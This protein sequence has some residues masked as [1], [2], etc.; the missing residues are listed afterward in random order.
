[1]IPF[2]A[3]AQELLVSRNALVE[4][5]AGAP[6]RALLPPEIAEKL[7]VSDW[8]SLDFGTRAGADDAAEWLE[9]LSSLLPLSPMVVGARLCE[10]RQAGRIDAAVV[11]QRGLVIQNGVW[12][13][14]EDYAETAPYYLFSFQ[15]AVES[16]ERSLGYVTV[17]LNGR[18]RAG[19]EQPER[20][21]GCLQN[22]LEEDRTFTLPCEP[23][24]ELYPVAARAAETEV[25]ARLAMLE[26]SA[27]RRLVRDSQRMESYYRGLLEH[28][29]KRAAR[30]PADPEAVG[31]EH[32]RMMATR[33]DRAAKLED[34][35]RKYSL[36]VQLGW[37]QVL[38]VP[39][40]VRAISVRLIR[41]KQERPL[42]LHWNAIS[43]ALDTPLCEACSARA[44]PLYLCEK[45]HLLC[46][47]CWSACPE[48]SRVFCRVCQPRCKCVA[49]SGRIS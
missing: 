10:R 19:T 31:K 44:R 21:F 39:L 37:T 34:L 36:R 4:S 17:G 29:E 32:D 25:R 16:D 26:Q 45:V 9:R 22:E 27:N 6:L 20:L 48:C 47:A 35:V 13:G 38:V 18:S 12:R 7:G 41:K 28:L 40:P 8:L 14:V 23:L 15:Y 11:L 5:E 30:R 1:V 49:S 33:L 42:L 24:R 43:R 3:W 46:G 2:S